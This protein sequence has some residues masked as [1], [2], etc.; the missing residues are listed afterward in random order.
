MEEYFQT[1]LKMAEGIPV[2]KKADDLKKNLS[3][4]QYTTLL[5]DVFKR[6]M[7]DQLKTYFS[8]IFDEALFAFRTGY[9]CQDMLLLYW[10]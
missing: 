8:D 3:T 9:S 2:Y 7:A 1:C 5:V 10:A 6:M 4:C